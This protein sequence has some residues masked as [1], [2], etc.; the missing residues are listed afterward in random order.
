MEV[1]LLRGSNMS[2]EFN[3]TGAVV[4]GT[5]NWYMGLKLLV[6][7]AWPSILGERNIG[8]W[9]GSGRWENCCGFGCCGTGT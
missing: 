6:Y 4:E 1:E 8:T 9:L 7:G 3:C 5:V 2:R